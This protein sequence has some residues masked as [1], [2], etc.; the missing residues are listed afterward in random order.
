MILTNLL[1]SDNLFRVIMHSFVDSAEGAGTELL[2]DGILT[3]RVIA[4]DHGYWRRA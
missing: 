3:S 2:K 4:R 1:D